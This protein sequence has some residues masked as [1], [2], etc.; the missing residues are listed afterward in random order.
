MKTIV[1]KRKHWG[2]ISMVALASIGFVLGL[3]ISL[4]ANDTH[5]STCIA[6]VMTALVISETQDLNW[7]NVYM[8]VAKAMDSATDDAGSG[9]SALW[10]IT[11]TAGD[12]IQ[13]ALLLP[14][15][16][17]STTV[18]Q[19]IDVFFKETD[20]SYCA[21]GTT[22]ADFSA[23]TYAMKNPFAM[24]SLTLTEAS[25]NIGLGGTVYPKATQLA[26]A[27]YQATIILTVWFEGA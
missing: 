14:E 23:G 9:G 16:L 19:R 4:D 17:W 26:A 3:G 12:N 22:N 24:G 20:A 25:G 5:Q 21:T 15:Y 6:T 7:G 8:G 18:K 13:A 1:N 11:G 10:K 2:A 27:D